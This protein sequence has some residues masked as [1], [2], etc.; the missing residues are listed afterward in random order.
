MIL[1]VTACLIAAPA[2]C[3]RFEA[4]TEARLSIECVF[5]MQAWANEHPAWR[6]TRWGCGRREVRA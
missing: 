1:V 3:E 4:P 5:A 6:V 2:T